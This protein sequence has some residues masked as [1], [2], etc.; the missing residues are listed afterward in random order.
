MANISLVLAGLQ[1]LIACPQL[2]EIFPPQKLKK[3]EIICSIGNAQDLFLM[4]ILPEIQDYDW[5]IRI[6]F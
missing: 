4:A 2:N 3:N 5:Y 1:L 6:A